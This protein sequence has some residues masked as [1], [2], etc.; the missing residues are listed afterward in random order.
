MAKYDH[1][2][3]LKWQLNRSIIGTI[4]YVAAVYDPL[5]G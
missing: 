5:Y 1:K 4:P 2:F 3:R